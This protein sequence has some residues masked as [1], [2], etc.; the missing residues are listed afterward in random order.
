MTRP[1][2]TSAVSIDN[3]AIYV[4]VR[5][6]ECGTFTE[7]N[8]HVSGSE[9]A[10]DQ[11]QDSEIQLSIRSK[12][13]VT[14]EALRFPETVFVGGGLGCTMMISFRTD[15]EVEDIASVRVRIAKQ[16]VEVEL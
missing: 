9:E 11:L 5:R 3:A 8:L 10:I 15:V 13:S 2:R 4:A 12:S 14:V 16:F 1:Q 6:S 7:C